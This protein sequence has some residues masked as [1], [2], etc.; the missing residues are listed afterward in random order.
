MHAEAWLRAH[1]GPDDVLQSLE[2][3]FLEAQAIFGDAYRD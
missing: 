1:G 3:A 2:T